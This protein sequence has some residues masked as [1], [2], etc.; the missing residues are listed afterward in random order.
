MKYP[1]ETCIGVRHYVTTMQKRSTKLAKIF[2]RENATVEA[3][4]LA[5]QRNLRGPQ[6]FDCLLAVTARQNQMDT[7]WTENTSD[8]MQFEEFMDV[9]NPFNRD[10]KLGI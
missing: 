10:W 1:C 6:V 3:I 8:F 7:I 4:E 2:P 9:E 5:K